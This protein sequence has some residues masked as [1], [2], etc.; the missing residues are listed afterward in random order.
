MCAL[1]GLKIDDLTWSETIAFLR[2][3]QLEVLSKQLEQRSLASNNL[4]WLMFIRWSRELGLLPG[5][6]FAENDCSRQGSMNLDAEWG[7]CAIIPSESWIRDRSAAQRLR[8]VVH[9]RTV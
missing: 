1:H 2:S 3:P 5:S 9:Q 7:R 8:R 4:L 6:R